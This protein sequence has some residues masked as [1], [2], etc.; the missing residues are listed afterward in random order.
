MHTTIFTLFMINTVIFHKHSRST[1]RLFRTI[2]QRGH[3][4]W[5]IN[6]PKLFGLKTVK[7]L[8]RLCGD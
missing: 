1:S 5:Q 6:C 3:E 4:P 8:I 2:L 7:A